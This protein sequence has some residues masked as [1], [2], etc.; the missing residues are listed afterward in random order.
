[1]KRLL[2]AVVLMCGI[3]PIKPIVPIGC[4]DLVAVCHCDQSGYNC[5]WVWECVQ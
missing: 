2:F 4:K 5:R 1:M 3:V